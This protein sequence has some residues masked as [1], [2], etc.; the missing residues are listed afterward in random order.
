[1]RKPLDQR[2]LIRA[3]FIVLAVSG[4]LWLLS[5]ADWLTERFSFRLD[6]AFLFGVVASTAWIESLRTIY[7]PL[8]SVAQYCQIRN[9]CP[10]SA[11]NDFKKH[12]GLA[13]KDGRNTRIVRDIAI[14]IIANL[15]PWSP[16][17]DRGAEGYRPYAKS[18][19]RTA[20]G[21]AT[22]AKPSPPAAAPAK[23][24]Q[25]STAP[26]THTS[27]SPTQPRRPRATAL[28]TMSPN[29]IGETSQR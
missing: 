29:V 9:C 16:E 2:T 3:G 18:R 1:M 10:A 7:P 22:A 12:P 27:P 6:D 8:L 20:T 13:L 15:P 4:C 21:L 26:P 5:Y 14:D 11:Y 24:R 17:C 28:S 19:P 25:R 23:P